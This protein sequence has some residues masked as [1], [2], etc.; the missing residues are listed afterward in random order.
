MINKASFENLPQ[1]VESIAVEIKTLK[2][3]IEHAHS[4]V[5]ET[6][7]VILNVQEA[8]ELLN[9]SVPTIYTKVSKKEI[10]Y[11][12]VINGKRIYF[13]KS[14]LIDYVKS[15]RRKS[16][17]DIDLEADKYIKNSHSL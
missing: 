14:E 10:P 17:K 8:A 1:M 11:N 6:P 16:Y 7:D 2:H 5:E 15:G 9:L 12:K 13:F 3:L 4:Q